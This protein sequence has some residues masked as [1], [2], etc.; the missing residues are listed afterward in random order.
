M[1]VQLALYDAAQ[2]SLSAG[3]YDTPWH[4]A[5]G[6]YDVE[7]TFVVVAIPFQTAFLILDSRFEEAKIPHFEIDLH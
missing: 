3:K 4:L 1:S 2:Y 5:P 7:E 6:N